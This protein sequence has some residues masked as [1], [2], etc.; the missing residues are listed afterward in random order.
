MTTCLIAVI[1]FF[2]VFSYDFFIYKDFIFAKSS[3]LLD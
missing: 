3:L 2:A 1:S